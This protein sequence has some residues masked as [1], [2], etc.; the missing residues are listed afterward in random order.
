MHPQRICSDLDDSCPKNHFCTEFLDTSLKL[1]K[2]DSFSLSALQVYTVITLEGWSE[3]MERT[4]VNYSQHMWIY[5][6][7][8]IMIGNYLMVNLT[9]AILKVKFQEA[10][11]SYEAKHKSS[12]QEVEYDLQELK[13]INIWKKR[14]KN[15]FNWYEVQ[16]VQADLEKNHEITDKKVEITVPNLEQQ[17]PLPNIEMYRRRKIVISISK[18]KSAKS[19]R[20]SNF[21]V[22]RSDI[23]YQYLKVKVLEIGYIKSSSQTNVV[24]E[25]YH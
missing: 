16:D 21:V 10:Q 7:S 18:L 22:F 24:G 15:I 4:L 12:I 14:K 2:F 9:L 25:R 13:C 19:V 6:F 8:L 11:K 3:V 23:L 1:D 5:F 20:N 17:V